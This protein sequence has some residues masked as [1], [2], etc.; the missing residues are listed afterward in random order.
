[1]S[2]EFL[3][4][5]FGALA[6]VATCVSAVALVRVNYSRAIIEALRGDRDDQEKR[7]IRQDA[8][9]GSLRS[10][11]LRLQDEN[12]VLRSLKTGE[13]AIA[14]LAAAHSESDRQ[15]AAADHDILAAVQLVGEMLSKSTEKAL[16]A[17]ERTAHT[18]PEA[19]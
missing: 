16:Q 5:L 11:V 17:F 19:S 3:T 10:D 6:A 2:L 14:A 13:T 8:E 7:I 15:R 4:A 18:H 12:Q 1:M 9:L